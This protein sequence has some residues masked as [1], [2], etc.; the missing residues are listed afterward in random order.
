M[1]KT[2][3]LLKCTIIAFYLF[4]TLSFSLLCSPAEAASNKIDLEAG[5]Y[6]LNARS[7]T[8][9]GSIASLGI[10][11]VGYRRVVS[12]HFD[13][14]I[15]YTV[16]FTKVIS[17]DAGFGLDLN[18]TYYFYGASNLVEAQ[19][20]NSYFA[21]EEEFR[22]YISLNFTQR[23][24]QSIQTS[25]AGFGGS[26]GVEKTLSEKL[27]AKI[28]ARYNMLSA[29]GTATAKELSFLGGIVIEF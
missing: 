2:T 26:L 1:K 3:K 22:P 9:S 13:I 15:G 6:S 10:Y 5:Y 29:G 14:G 25:Y 27:S 16:L 23:N 17:G 18:G 20:P 8:T 12:P 7:A 19:G 21:Y 24:Y 28:S 11:R 4:T